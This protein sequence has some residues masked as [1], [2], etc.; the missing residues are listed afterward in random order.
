[1]KYGALSYLPLLISMMIIPVQA[2]SLNLSDKYEQSAPLATDVQKKVF[3]T[4]FEIE[5]W[6]KSYPKQYDQDFT[7]NIIFH[8]QFDQSDVVDFIAEESQEIH[9]YSKDQYNAFVSVL[10]DAIACT[11]KPKSHMSFNYIPKTGIQVSCEQQLKTIPD[12]PLSFYLLDVFLH[13]SSEYENL[14]K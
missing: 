3:S 1:M 5:L 9:N 8:S 6:G 2:N 12:G 14:K 7:I 11:P 4:L 10:T 13:P